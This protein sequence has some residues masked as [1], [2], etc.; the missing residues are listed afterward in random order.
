LVNVDAGERALG[1]GG[2]FVIGTDP[3]LQLTAVYGTCCGHGTSH[4]VVDVMGYYTP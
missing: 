4:L 3:A 1:N 2:I